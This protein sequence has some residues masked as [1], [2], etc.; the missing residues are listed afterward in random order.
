MTLIR[1]ATKTE[2]PRDGRR[3]LRPFRQ[4]IESIF[5]T[6]KGQLDLERHGGRTKGGVVARVSNGY[7]PSPPSSGTTKPP[8]D[9]AQPAPS[10][11]MTTKTLE[12]TI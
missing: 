10:S 8:N 11:H 3:F 6:F 1:P 9:Q 4:I 7:S 5:Q 12:L 2:A